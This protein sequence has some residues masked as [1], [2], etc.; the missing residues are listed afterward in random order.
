M[1]D[2][3]ALADEIK[4]GLIAEERPD[5]GLK[6][7]SPTKCFLCQTSYVY[8]GTA[9][10]DSGRFCSARCRNA[11]DTVGLRY[12]PVSVRYVDATGRAMAATRSGLVINCK[13]C[14]QEFVSLGIVF[15]SAECSRIYRDRQEAE[16]IAREVGHEPRVHRACVDCGVRIPRYTASGCATRATVIRCRKC[17]RKAMLQR[18]SI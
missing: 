5:V 7:G 8:Q 2:R 17:Q 14:R 16:V 12:R 11:Y 13:G 18:R 9:G 1:F 6:L 15:C 10:D 4:A 3:G